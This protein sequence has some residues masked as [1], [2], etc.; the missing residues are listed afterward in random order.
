VCTFTQSTN[1]YIYTLNLQ[2]ERIS[3]EGHLYQ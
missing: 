3:E 1:I 2:N